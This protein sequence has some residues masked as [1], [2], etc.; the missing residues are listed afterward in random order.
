MF[1]TK[2]HDKAEPRGDYPRKVASIEGQVTLAFRASRPLD[3]RQRIGELPQ[4]KAPVAPNP[5]QN[6]PRSHH[7]PSAALVAP[8]PY[9]G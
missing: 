2:D 9:L 7:K 6:G 1:K 3:T 5:E 8:G 4:R